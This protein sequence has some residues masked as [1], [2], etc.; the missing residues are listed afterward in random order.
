MD[1]IL[2]IS[3]ISFSFENANFLQSYVVEYDDDFRLGTC[4]K[5][6]F[7]KRYYQMKLFLVLPWL[8]RPHCTINYK[9]MVETNSS[10]MECKYEI[11]PF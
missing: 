1:W 11:T 6:K 2:N 3:I 9:S 8:E 10:V 7:G 4:W 5:H